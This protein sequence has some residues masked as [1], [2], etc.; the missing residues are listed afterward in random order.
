M[1]IRNNLNLDVLNSLKEYI[2]FLKRYKPNSKL[3]RLSIYKIINHLEI[4]IKYYP[5]Y[6]NTIKKIINGQSLNILK[7]L[8]NVYQKENEF[9]FKK[10]ILLTI[11][12]AF[13]LITAIGFIIFYIMRLRKAA[14]IDYL[15]GLYNRNRLIYELRYNKYHVLF[16][17]GIED[18]KHIN[19]FYGVK[20]GDE[21][22]KLF[23]KRLKKLVSSCCRGKIYRLGSDDFGIL[24]RKQYVNDPETLANYIINNMENNGFRIQQWDIPISIAIGISLEEP[25]LEKADLTLK[26]VKQNP[27]L[28]YAVYTEEIMKIEKNIENNMKILKVLKS[29]LE[30][31]RIVP[32]YQPILDNKIGKVVKY[33]SLVR[34]FNEKGEMLLPGEFLEVA[35]KG[36]LYGEITKCVIE[37][38]FE[39]FKENPCE[40]SVNLSVDDIVDVSIRLFI[41]D[42]LRKNPELSKRVMFE[43]LESEG[44]ENFD[45]VSKFIKDIKQYGATIAIDDFGTGYSNF[46]YLLQLDVDF[47]KIDGSLI[48]DIH[49]N[50]NSEIIVKTIVNFAK[51]LN[52]KTVA[53]FVHNYEVHRKVIE[54]GIDYSQGYFL[55]KPSP[56]CDLSS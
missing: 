42:K 26:Y 54:L 18:F 46:S 22:L 52:I 35:K 21:F 5:Y 45:I 34:A 24:L 10:F 31:N 3:E 43:I 25:F 38:T 53:E 2:N 37:K 47:I 1:L 55:G 44:I 49:I 41:I 56:T 33:E 32:Y 16:I 51:K 6:I 48:K 12:F 4:F 50:K 20:I 11:L 28:K 14:S 39:Y 36:K 30:S 29:A 19:N 17:V 9:I 40:F 27:R 8:K 23:A 7:E 15:T 13:G